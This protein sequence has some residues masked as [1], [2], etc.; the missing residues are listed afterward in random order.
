MQVHKD[1]T[2]ARVMEAVEADDNVGFCISCGEEAFYVEPDAR[3]YECE[4]CGEKKV[5]G[6]SELLIQQLHN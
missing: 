3:K 1:V 6:A 5:Y 4:S 2:L